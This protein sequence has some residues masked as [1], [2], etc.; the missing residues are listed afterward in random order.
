[1]TRRTP[2]CL[3]KLTIGFSSLVNNTGAGP[4]PN[5]IE[6]NFKKLLSPFE[7]KEKPLFRAEGNDKVDV[8][9]SNFASQSPCLTAWRTAFTPSILKCWSGM[10][11]FRPFKF[12]ISLHPPKILVQQRT[13]LWNRHR[14]RGGGR[15]LLE[16]EK[17]SRCRKSLVVDRSLLHYVGSFVGWEWRWNWDWGRVRPYAKL[18]G[19]RWF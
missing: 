12:T 16:V 3:R 7:L 1:M 8:L 13:R 2:R 14:L 4:R 6:M 10:N 9:Q 17:K 15:A 5:G 11:W 18:T 19:R